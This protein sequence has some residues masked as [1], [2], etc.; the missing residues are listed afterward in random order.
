MDVKPKKDYIIRCSNVPLT[1]LNKPAAKDHFSQF[2]KVISIHLRQKTKGCTVQYANEEGF[3][4]ALSNAGVFNGQT[5]TVVG[6]GVKSMKWV[7]PKLW[8]PN[9][10]VQQELEAMGGTVDYKLVGKVKEKKPKNIWGSQKKSTTKG[11]EQNNPIN[12]KVTSEQRELLNVIKQPAHSV[13]EKFKVL[14][15]RDKLLR[16]RGNKHVDFGSTHTVGTCPDMCPEKERLMREVQ[17]QVALYEQ[18]SCSKVMNHSL[19]VKQYSRSSADQESPLPHELRSVDVLRMTMGYLMHKI[20]P[21][22]DNFDVNLAEWYHFLWDRTRGIRKDI[23]Q[24]ELCCQ[25]SVELVEQCA[26]FHIH[27]SAR[28]IAEDPSVFDQKINTENLTKCLQT[29]KYMYHDLLCKNEFCEHEAEFRGYIILLNLND[30]NFMWEVQQL[31]SDIQKSQPVQF[32]IQVYSALDTNNYVKFFKLVKS[33]TYLNACILLRYFIQV[34][35]RALQTILKGFSP[36]GLTKFPLE[37]LKEIL[38]F[39]G[40]ASTRDFVEYYGLFLNGAAVC[41]NRKS[42]HIPELPYT[43]DRAMSVVESKRVLSIGEIISGGVLPPK[44][45]ETHRVHSSFDEFG[46][47]T[48]FNFDDFDYVDEKIE[49]KSI[50]GLKKVDSRSNSPLDVVDSSIFGGKK[51]IFKFEKKFN[52]ESQSSMDVEAENVNKP[53]FSAKPIFSTTMFQQ[54]SIFKPTPIKNTQNMPSGGFYFKL[55]EDKKDLKPLKVGQEENLVF[56]LQKEDEDERKKEFEEMERIENERKR[57]ENEL[58]L[59]L[60]LE[61]KLEVERKLE[62]ERKLE[63]E[64]KMELE[65]K[66]RLELKRKLELEKKLEKERIEE[67]KKLM[68][69]KKCVSNLLNDLLTQVEEKN[70]IE[71]LQEMKTKLINEKTKLFGK[72]W[73]K[74]VDLKK[75]KRKNLDDWPLWIETDNRELI[76]FD[77]TILMDMKRYKSGKSNQIEL[78]P[79]L[80]DELNLDQIFI[81]ILKTNLTKFE[82]YLK[83]DFCFSKKPSLKKIEE[84]LAELLDLDSNI[85]KSKH[86]LGKRVNYCFK[87]YDYFNNELNHGFIFVN[88]VFDDDFYTK[89]EEILKNFNNNTPLP[90]AFILNESINPNHVVKL[91]NFDL[92]SNY[93]VFSDNFTS[94]NL[95]I[96]LTQSLTFLIKNYPPLPTL[97]LDYFSSFLFGYLSG[98]SWDRI[99]NFAETNKNFAMILCD[100]NNVFY[101]YKVLLKNLQGIIFNEDL[102]KNKNFPKIFNNNYNDVILPCD[103]KYFPNFWKN[104]SYNVK[105]KRIF[106]N[107]KFPEFIVINWPP[108]NIEELKDIIENVCD[109]FNCPARTSFVIYSTLIENLENLGSFES[110]K[111]MM[112]TDIIKMMINEK[113]RIIDFTLREPFVSTLF[114]QLFVVYDQDDLNKFKRNYWFFN[115]EFI[116]K[117]INSS[118]RMII[119]DEDE[120]EEEIMIKSNIEDDFDFD[121]VYQEV[122]GCDD[123]KD[124][125]KKKKEMR[126]IGEML[127]DLEESIRIQKKI[128]SRLEKTLLLQL[129]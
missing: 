40:D 64:R 111:Y 123:H 52:D 46:Y 6:G 18:E 35:V 114:N 28:L 51:S 66:V 13:D 10:E 75:R 92:I 14:E 71:K 37:E 108:N 22:C 85:N 36:R 86:I 97:K 96:L 60:E 125:T 76:D 84:K 59:K 74:L 47:L 101:L 56:S 50:F 105:L 99:N 57:V 115:D 80:N 88:D 12:I 100:P 38:A 1:L 23:T 42:F 93:A 77:Q 63:M 120:F 102:V 8:T 81:D 78:T 67:N 95:K 29:L 39:E 118:N 9:L 25:G 30:G 116:Q 62:L 65:K 124:V 98:E 126:E 70:R 110:I 54:E 43:L 106:E 68:E 69:I 103:Q 53:V 26:R 117:E 122:M 41:L 27:C 91:N 7:T 17:H 5:F 113:L 58:K 15:A 104:G 34:R 73:L 49:D 107:L 16:L 33:T 127:N 45:F 19:A 11:I 24:Q 2:G 72:K 87:R 4:C 82:Y 89:L 119:E 112:W 61:R 90:V 79:K 31:R 129:K 83:I 21:L 55:N 48:E 3:Q 32:A 44:M 109:R 20:I 94:H 121:K 128:S